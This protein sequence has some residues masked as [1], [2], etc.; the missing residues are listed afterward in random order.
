MSGI[1]RRSA[2]ALGL[3]AAPAMVRAH[4]SQCVAPAKPGGGFDMTCQLLQALLAGPAGPPRIVY[5]PG[6]IGA[7]AYRELVRG[8]RQDPRELIAFSTGTLLNI[9]QGRF[10]AWRPDRLHWVAGVAMDHGVVAVAAT[11]PWRTLGDLLDALRQQPT[12]VAFAAGGTI[13]SQ[14]WMKAALLARAVGVSHRA[15]RIVAFEGGGD[16]LRALEGGHVHVLCGDAAE[17][18]P[19]LGP[20]R[21][22]VRLLA[23]LSASR[24][25]GALAAVPTAAEQ[26]VDVRWPIL[27][28]VYT[29]ADH[30]DAERLALVERLALALR[31]PEHA[32]RVRASGMTPLALT[33]EPLAREVAGQLEALREMAAG[34]GLVMPR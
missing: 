23:T 10:G 2:L 13:G 21:G 27:R 7:L 9:A 15:L 17:L 22:G 11:A 12:A 6:G 8:Q 16:A 34:F 18:L 29:S 3:A 33:G 32:A 19:R 26:G 24:L 14:D 25:A 31:T 30:P 20:Q 1:T 4:V 28:G 5:Q